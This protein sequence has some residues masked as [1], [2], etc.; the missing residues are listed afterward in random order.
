MAK[1]PESKKTIKHYKEI[2]DL[3][4][5]IEFNDGWDDE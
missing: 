4:H 1:I 2:K 3:S 5:T